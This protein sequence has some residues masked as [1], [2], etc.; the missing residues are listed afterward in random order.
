MRRCH[1]PFFEVYHRLLSDLLEIGTFGGLLVVFH[2]RRARRAQL[3]WSRDQGLLLR[4]APDR[5]AGWLCS[6]V[7]EGGVVQLP[8]ADVLIVASCW[9]LARAL[10]CHGLCRCRCL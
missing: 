6:H 2:A 3:P 7:V 5:C 9:L 10:L 8:R 1:Y 4:V